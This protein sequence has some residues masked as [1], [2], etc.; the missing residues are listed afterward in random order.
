[1]VEF[2]GGI[3]L[4]KA[5]DDGYTWD[6]K[7]NS[8][9][10][11]QTVRDDL[12]LQQDVAYNTTI[13]LDEELGAPMTPLTLNR[14]TARVKE[15]LNDEPRILRVSVLNVREQNTDTV[16]IVARVVSDAGEQELVFEV[17]Q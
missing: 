10:D 8:V 4:N 14:I 3:Y 16:E 5:S 9:G 15:A 7:L 1:M 6:L 2:G 17:E 11:I 13:E 12:L